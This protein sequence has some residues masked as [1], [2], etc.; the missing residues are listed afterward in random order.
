MPC[1]QQRESNYG[2]YVVHYFG[3]DL[4]EEEKEDDRNRCE[5]HDVLYIY[6]AEFFH[7]H[8]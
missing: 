1:D 8:P 7:G 6:K 4:P 2:E 5:H 3:P